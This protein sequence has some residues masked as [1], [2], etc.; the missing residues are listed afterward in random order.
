MNSLTEMLQL[1]LGQVWTTKQCQWTIKAVS[2]IFEP[3]T[4]EI[5]FFALGWI[6]FQSYDAVTHR[7]WTSICS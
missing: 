2:L 7:K 5:T 4:P 1:E 3:L 6:R